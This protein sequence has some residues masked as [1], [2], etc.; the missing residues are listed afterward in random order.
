[1]ADSVCIVITHTRAWLPAA[2]LRMGGAG[3][4]LPAEGLNPLDSRGARSR[5]ETGLM[6]QCWRLGRERLAKVG[7]PKR[8]EGDRRVRHRG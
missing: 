2:R 4:R 3:A 8:R 7:P 6:K 5:R 1:M